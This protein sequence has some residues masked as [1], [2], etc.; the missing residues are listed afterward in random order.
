MVTQEKFNEICDGMER[1]NRLMEDQ[2]SKAAP[3]CHFRKMYLEQSD[4]IDGY[5]EEW[6]ECS[7]CGHTS[8]L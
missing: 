5:Y 8:S 3:M 1:V 6:W 2:I 7:V 4:S